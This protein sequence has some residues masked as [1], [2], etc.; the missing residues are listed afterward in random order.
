[1]L[2]GWRKNRNPWP[3]R[4][5]VE[6]VRDA[7]VEQ[8]RVGAGLALNG[9]AAVTGIPGERVVARP[10]IRE[11]VA[12]VSVDGVVV[13]AAEEPLGPAAS[14]EVVVARVAAQGRGLRVGEDAVRLVDEDA[15][16]AAERE[17]EDP[18]EPVPVDLPLGRA[19][20]ADVDLKPMRL[21]GLQPQDDRLAPGSAD[22]GQHLLADVTPD[23]GLRL[24]V[25]RL[26]LGPLLRLGQGLLLRLRQGGLLGL[27]LRL[28]R[29]GAIRHEQRPERDEHGDDERRRRRAP[30]LLAGPI[31]IVGLD[32][33]CSSSDGCCTSGRPCST[34]R[35]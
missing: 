15:V 29:A 13:E 2:A 24:L 30:N 17:D 21:A 31:T 6:G 25:L 19:V 27:R 1:M 33:M 34:R 10:E 32:S 28:G 5:D 20:V 9:V 8:H 22:H 11:I 14:P 12:S 26:D 23:L 3:V 16:V 7:A 4:G 18:I 35:R